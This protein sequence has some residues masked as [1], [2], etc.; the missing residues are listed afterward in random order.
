MLVKE[1][2][3]RLVW[4]LLY[5]IFSLSSIA[6]NFFRVFF[7]FPVYSILRKNV[8]KPISFSYSILVYASFHSMLYSCQFVATKY[9]LLL[10]D[11]FSRNRD[12]FPI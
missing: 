5:P 12:A 4:N 6:Y 1:A 8:R 9:P 3:K 11:S 10:V 2:Q 7:V